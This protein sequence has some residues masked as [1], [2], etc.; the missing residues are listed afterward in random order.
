MK[1]P[2]VT[3][4]TSPG[5]PG[6]VLTKRHLERRGVAFSEVNISDDPLN[7]D[8]IRELGFSSAPVVCA[9]TADGELVWGGYRPDRIDMLAGVK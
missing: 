1:V 3:V 6:C 4:Y 9:S 8:A 7:L 2:V 5:C